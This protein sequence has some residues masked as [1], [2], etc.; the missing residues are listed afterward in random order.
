MTHRSDDNGATWQRAEEIGLPESGELKL[1]RTWHVEPGPA[2]APTV[3]YV[4]GTPGALL[5]SND[6][7]ATWQPVAGIVEHRLAGA[8]T[9]RVVAAVAGG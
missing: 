1:E 9:V 7:G 2:D 6:G 4:G 5:R 8:E 3:L